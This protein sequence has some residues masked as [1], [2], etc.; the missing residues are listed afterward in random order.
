[1]TLPMDTDEFYT[2]ND[3]AYSEKMALAH[4]SMRAYAAYAAT[5]AGVV[6]PAPGKLGRAMCHCGLV[7]PV[8]PNTTQRKA[9]HLA[10]QENALAAAALTAEVLGTDDES[11]S[12][13]Q[14]AA[15]EALV[16]AMRGNLNEVELKI[17]LSSEWRTVSIK[18]IAASYFK[19]VAPGSVELLRAMGVTA[20]AALNNKT[21]SVVDLD[22]KYEYLLLKLW[23]EANEAMRVWKK[24]HGGH[25]KA[26]YVA[27]R[28]NRDYK[29]LEV[30]E[31]EFLHAYMYNVRQVITTGATA[32][33]EYATANDFAFFAS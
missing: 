1:M 16:T 8:L 12:D 26:E 15:D 31:L 29:G 24:A 22:R 25:R 17:T 13:E 4:N 27:A 21:V 14:V 3:Q 18:G 33:G 5:S 30:I 9:W 6:E 10:H 28:Q 2:T 11:V 23:A 20:W 32:F 7:S 19:I